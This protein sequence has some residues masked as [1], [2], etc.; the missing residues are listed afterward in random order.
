[1]LSRIKLLTV[2]H[3]QASLKQVSRYVLP[4]QDRLEVHQQLHAL[5]QQFGLDELMYM[6]TCNR[7]VFCF[8]TQKR[9]DQSLVADFLRAINP[10]LTAD[11]IAL[12]Q[13]MKGDKAVAH[14]MQ[15]AS[16]V[17]SMV[18]GEREILHQLRD[19]YEECT[20]SGL[21][22]EMLKQVMDSV[23]LAAKDV[24]TRTRIGQKPVS[25]V[26]LAGEQLLAAKLPRDARILM[27]GAGQ[28]NAAVAKFL[29]KYEYSN[30][31]VFNRTV[32]KA[33]ELAQ[34]LGGRAFPLEY[35][36][37]YREGFDCL[38]V[39]TGIPQAIVTKKCYE[40]LL[41]GDT[42]HKIVVDLAI[43]YNVADDV[44]TSFPMTHIEIE[45]LRTLADENK[46]FRE[47]E[48]GQALEIVQEHLEDFGRLF[49][50]R[51]VTKAM[52]QLPAQIHE[53]RMRASEQVFRKRLEKLNDEE[54]QLFEDMLDYMERNCIGL[55][56]KVAREAVVG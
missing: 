19:A 30:V 7:V 6:A 31:T 10:D 16:S 38:I 47:R 52:G 11:D 26:A 39:C 46:A 33:E 15:V 27:I 54:R 55:P 40:A 32:Q 29:H 36:H 2:T 44:P 4:E 5:R 12:V 20:A 25:I 8:A 53:V 50:M 56:M 48:V 35:I 28:T 24:F 51:L 18:V 17:D 1:M 3:R 21:T 37:N 41:N 14:L 34:M 45:G 22:G 9:L 42:A 43:P 13:R 49:Q 23:V